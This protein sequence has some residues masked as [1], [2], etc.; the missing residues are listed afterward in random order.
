MVFLQDAGDPLALEPPDG[1][2][3]REGFE[4]SL[5]H[6]LAAGV[7]LCQRTDAF[8]GIGEITAAS[9]GNGHLGEGLGTGFKH[10]YSQLW[11]QAP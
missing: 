7:S 5:H 10:G 9:S 6:A 1:V 8:E 11:C 4:G 2:F 3:L